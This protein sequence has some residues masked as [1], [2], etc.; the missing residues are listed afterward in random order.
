MRVTFFYSIVIVRRSEHRGFV[1]ILKLN[2]F[3]LNSAEVYCLY[4]SGAES[5]KLFC[6]MHCYIDDASSCRINCFIH[7]NLNKKHSFFYSC[8]KTLHYVWNFCGNALGSNK[9]FWFL[10][11]LR[12][13]HY[14][15]VDSVIS[16]IFSD[17]CFLVR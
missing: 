9:L 1:Q 13:Y 17:D 15:Y 12:E 2:Y 14:F 16:I 10:M 3:N 7:F 11:N 5:I 6:L 8:I 4:R